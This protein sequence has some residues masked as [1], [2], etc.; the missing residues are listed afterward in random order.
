M[1]IRSLLATAAICGL[2][3]NANADLMPYKD[4]DIGSDLLSVT[5]VKVKVNSIDEYLEGLKQ[6][7]VATNEIAKEL[8][9]IKDYGI[10]VSQLPGSGDFNVILVVTLESA[11]DLQPDQAE[12]EKFMNKWGQENA[13]QSQQVSKNYP[14]VREITGEYHMREITIK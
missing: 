1:R 12:F 7:W 3:M 9:Q 13:D 8:G 14:N 10:Y 11:N 2:A 4:Y 6:T 5:T